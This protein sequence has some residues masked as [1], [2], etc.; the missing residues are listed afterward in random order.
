MADEFGFNMGNVL[1]NQGQRQQNEMYK[2]KNELGRMEIDAYK[3]QSKNAPMVN[4]L[5]L[6]A[7]GG[8]V[9]AQKQYLA[10]DPVNGPAFIEALNKMD[11]Q[12]KEATQLKV[13]QMG[14]QFVR[15][16]QEPK[17]ENRVRMYVELVSQLP[18]ERRAQVPSEY[19]PDFVELQIAKLKTVDQLIKSPDVKQV[20]GQDRVY[21][22]GKEIDRATRPVK[23]SKEDRPKT[24]KASDEAQLYKQLAAVESGFLDPVT[25][26]MSGWTTDGQKRTAARMDQALKLWKKKPD[27]LLG[28]VAAEVMRGSGVNLLTPAQMTD[29]KDPAAIGEFLLRKTNRSP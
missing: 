29:P 28:E 24:L 18:E 15:I 5:K 4:Q 14:Q 16:Q 7:A 17:P 12:Q 8:N 26:E 25:N 3:A 1:R 9:D 21:K 6:N 10:L 27:M 20:G 2:Q 23:L 11:A 22:D 13:N 19:N